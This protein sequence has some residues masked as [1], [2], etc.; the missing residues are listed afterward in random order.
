[1]E[2]QTQE[3]QEAQ[4]QEAQA[5]EAQEAQ[6][7]AQSLSPQLESLAQQLREKSP[8]ECKDVIGKLSQEEINEIL[9]A[10]VEFVK[11][12]TPILEISQLL[13]KFLSLFPDEDVFRFLQR[14]KADGL[15]QQVCDSLADDPN[16]FHWVRMSNI[17]LTKSENDFLY[18]ILTILTKKR[19]IIVPTHIPIGIYIL[20]FLENA[21]TSLRTREITVELR[22]KILDFLVTRIPE[23]T[24]KAILGIGP[25]A[26]FSLDIWIIYIRDII[27]KIKAQQQ[28]SE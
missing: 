25:T 27:Q 17:L 9:D 22:E 2:A 11:G 19:Y 7:Q 13:S 1:M 23:R 15:L 5:Q 14:I 21:M 24:L 18:Q 8:M 28:R 16:L 20:R 10:L 12:G 4:A 6:A 26:R 3:A